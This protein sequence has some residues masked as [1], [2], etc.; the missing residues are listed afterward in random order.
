M[1]QV[2]KAHVVD[3]QLSLMST[4]DCWSQVVFKAFSPVSFMKHWLVK[5]LMEAAGMGQEVEVDVVSASGQC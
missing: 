1:W 4:P 5:M 3:F 2:Q